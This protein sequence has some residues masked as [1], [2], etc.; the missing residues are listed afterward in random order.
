MCLGVDK[1]FLHKKYSAYAQT[2]THTPK[3]AVMLTQDELER[4]VVDTMG[5]DYVEYGVM[6]LLTEDLTTEEGKV[7][8]IT[9]E[10]KEVRTLT[11]VTVTGSGEGA[12]L[13]IF[14]ALKS[15]FGEE[16]PSLNYIYPISFT[17]DVQMPEKRRQSNLAEPLP[18]TFVFE[19]NLGRRFVFSASDASSTR[20][21]ASAILKCIVHFVNAERAVLKVLTWI[22]DADSRKRP[23]LVDRYTRLLAD[24]IEN[25]SYSTSIERARRAAKI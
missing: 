21:I 20:A 10:I 18:A 11:S 5:D 19:N 15:K 8:N 2:T 7:T 16:H 1:V 13:T 3:G 25:A 4:L 17:G 12:A 9:C 23:G 24:L 14:E 6:R 22:A